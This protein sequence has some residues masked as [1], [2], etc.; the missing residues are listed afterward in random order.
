MKLNTSADLINLSNWLLTPN[1]SLG[2]PREKRTD[3]DDICFS[4]WK[5]TTS[6]DFN[7]ISNWWLS[8][9]FFSGYPK[10][11]KMTDEPIIA[12]SSS[13]SVG[14]NLCFGCLCQGQSTPLCRPHICTKTS[15]HE[16]KIKTISGACANKKGVLIGKCLES[17]TLSVGNSKRRRVQQ[18]KWRRN[19]KRKLLSY[20]EAYSRE[21]SAQYNTNMK[22]WLPKNHDGFNIHLLSIQ[23]EA[24]QWL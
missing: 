5:L 11:T 12:C 17:S 21:H 20:Q 2:Y 15:S 9:N 23:T 6:V 16:D 4:S 3:T 8:L 19:K 7:N 1:F 14:T 10:K 18:P 24:V 22:V 13:P